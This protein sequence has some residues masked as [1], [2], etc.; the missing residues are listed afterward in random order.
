MIKHSLK[1]L[2]SLPL[3]QGRLLILTHDNPDPDCLA[4]SAALQYLLAKKKGI[5]A[6]VAYS[7][8]IGRAENRAMVRLLELDIRHVVTLDFGDFRYIAL[9]D[10]QPRTG[11][12]AVPDDRKVDIVIDHHPLRD[13]T[14]ESSFYEVR[15]R[16]GATATIL[17]EYLRLAE[18]EIPRDL[19][20][21]L[22]YGIRSETQDL[23]R[24]VSHRDRTAY[25]FLFPLADTQ[26]LAAISRPA[27]EPRYYEQLA[28]A[29][30]SLEYGDR[31]AVC[32]MGEVGEPDFV[33]EI[34][35]LAVRMEG[36]DWVLATG[37]HHGR[38][39]LS[40]RTNDERSNA[41]EVMQAV[42]EGIGRGGGHG[43]RGGG[44][45]ALRENGIRREEIEPELKRRFLAYTGDAEV[46]LRPI[47]R[48]SK[49]VDQAVDP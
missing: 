13:S 20:T 24:E 36:I 46:V 26:K 29:L 16:L 38:L 10:A 48:A 21:G 45:V 44:A 15:P 31:R 39:Y 18:L 37:T 3:D 41:G 19:A 8:I 40:V 30:D 1:R 34:A 47:R 7:G 25:Q 5:D 2:L 28:A 35:D 43:M 32:S 23:G 14:R 6:V 17:T 12:T 49:P 27:L 42:L 4:S 22:L 33:P 9:I 11:N